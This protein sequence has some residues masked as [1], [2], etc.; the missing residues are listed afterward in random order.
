MVSHHDFSEEKHTFMATKEWLQMVLLAFLRAKK[1]EHL[2]VQNT[3]TRT[4]DVAVMKR[5]LEDGGAMMGK[6]MPWT[7]KN[8]PLVI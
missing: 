4:V 5:S 1:T 8:A 6:H 7:S 3:R 2:V